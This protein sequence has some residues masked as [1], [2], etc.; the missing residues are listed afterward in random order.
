[1]LQY[2]V[3]IKMI[4]TRLRTAL[5]TYSDEFTRKERSMLDFLNEANLS[6]VTLKHP[7]TGALYK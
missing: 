7:K 1:M 6:D 5:K 4:P 3:K 2:A